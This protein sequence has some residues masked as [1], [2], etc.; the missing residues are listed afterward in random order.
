MGGK[1]QHW[2]KTSEID[3]ICKWMDF[4]KAQKETIAGG[5]IEY[6]VSSKLHQLN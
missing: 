5:K 3:I 6:Q 2:G 1:R 4:S